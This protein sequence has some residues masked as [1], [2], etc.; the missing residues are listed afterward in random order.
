MRIKK[1][2]AKAKKSKKAQLKT[3]EMA[4]MLVAVVIVFILAGLFFIVIKYRNLP[5]V[6]EEYERGKALSLINKLSDTAEFSCGEQSELC[7]DTD[8]LMVLKNRKEYAGFWPVTSITLERI[9]PKDVDID[10]ECTQ[11]NYPNCGIIRVYQKQVKSEEKISTYV[12]LC[13]KEGDAASGW[14]YNKCELGKMLLGIEPK[15]AWKWKSENSCVV[16]LKF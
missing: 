8:K 16:C 1:I 15:E 13:R 5:K 4:F 12:S 6:A 7:V 11:T 3:Q 2:K 9:F 10:K 14:I